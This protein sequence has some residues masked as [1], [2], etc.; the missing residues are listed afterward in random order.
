[1]SVTHVDF[2]AV[3]ASVL[4]QWFGVDPDLVLFGHFEPVEL[5]RV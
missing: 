3:Y 5:L 2:R 4:R 1:M